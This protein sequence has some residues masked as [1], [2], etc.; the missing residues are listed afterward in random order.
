MSAS[1]QTLQ[2]FSLVLSSSGDLVEGADTYIPFNVSR[3]F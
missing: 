2:D 3:I 1:L